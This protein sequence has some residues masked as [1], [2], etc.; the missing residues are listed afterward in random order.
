MKEK[1]EAFQPRLIDRVIFGILAVLHTMNGIYLVGPWYLDQWDEAGKAP[2]ANVFNSGLAVAAY[3]FFLL[4]NGL[5][6]LWATAAQSER[7]MY[8]PILSTVLLTGFL[9][10]LYSLIGVIIVLES[11]RPPSYLSHLATVVLCGAMW[12]YVRVSRRTIQ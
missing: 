10:R 8:I 12:V 11:W 6:L 9:L 1:R 4:L 3:G 5:L 7:K 2:L